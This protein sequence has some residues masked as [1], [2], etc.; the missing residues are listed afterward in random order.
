[1]EKIDIIYKEF[2]EIIS[3]KDDSLITRKIDELD[4]N[5]KSSY[6]SFKSL[7]DFKVTQE[8]NQIYISNIDLKRFVTMLTNG[9]DVSN[10][11]EVLYDDLSTS[12]KAVFDTFYTDFIL[13]K[14]ILTL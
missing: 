11:E 5:L 6:K 12:E 10:I 3:R 7:V 13:I 4:A 1:M 9:I 8:N 14:N 2:N